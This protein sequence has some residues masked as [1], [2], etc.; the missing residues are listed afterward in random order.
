M[1]YILHDKEVSFTEREQKGQMSFVR[2]MIEKK[3]W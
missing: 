1:S 2:Q 3:G